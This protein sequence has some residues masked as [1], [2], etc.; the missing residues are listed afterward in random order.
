M[1]DIYIERERERVL[2]ALV[3]ELQKLEK[4]LFSDTNV[5]HFKM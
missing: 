5:L 1:G 4:I 3:F 2:E